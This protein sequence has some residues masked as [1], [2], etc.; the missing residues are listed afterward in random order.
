VLLLGV[1]AAF[2]LAMGFFALKL[3]MDAGFE[4]QMPLGHEYVQTFN[5]YRAQLFGAN[6]ITIAVR[7][8][9]ARSGPRRG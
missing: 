8:V 1:L 6:R 3:R 7:A 5:Q 4:K 2:T 9:E